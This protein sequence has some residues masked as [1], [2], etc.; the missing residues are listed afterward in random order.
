LTDA[1]PITKDDALSS[2]KIAY[3][4][5][6]RSGLSLEEI[7][8][9]SNIILQELIESDEI[10]LLSTRSLGMVKDEFVKKLGDISFDTIRNAIFY[11]DQRV[12]LSPNESLLMDIFLDNPGKLLS[13]QEIVDHVVDE[14]NSPP[15]EVCRPIISRLRSHLS[16]IPSGEKWVETVRGRGYVFKGDK[17]I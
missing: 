5:L 13:H 12:Q 9:Y 3:H 8:E 17:N 6:I 15:A 10:T 7:V 14:T 1:N 11:G 16:A 4:A 2:L